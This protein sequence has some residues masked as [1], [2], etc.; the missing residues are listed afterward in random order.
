MSNVQKADP[1]RRLIKVMIALLVLF[2]LLLTGY[3]LLDSYQKGQHAQEQR[4]VIEANNQMIEEYNKALLAQRSEEVPDVAP[5]WPA[6]KAEGIDIVGLKGFAVKGEE[7][8]TVTRSEALL[9][10]LLVVN[11]WH[12]LPADFSL[13]EGQLDSI[14][15]L[16]NRRVPSEKREISLFPVAITALDQMI[17]AAKADGLEYFLVRGGYRSMQTQT[18]YWDK[19]VSDLGASGRLTGDALTEEARKAVAYPGTS[20]Y[21]S[22]F[23][24]ELDAYSSNDPV[25]NQAKFQ[26]TEQAKWLYKN[27]PQYGYVFRFPLAGYPYS[28]TVDKSYKTGINLANMDVYR[29]VGVPHA[30]V[31]QQKGFCLEEYI[32]YLIEQGHIAVY[33][34]GK[35]IHEIFRVEEGSVQTDFLVPAGSSKVEC[36]SDNLG[37]LICAVTY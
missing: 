4:R 28:T 8:Q 22:G 3:L 2:V 5:A 37:G 1:Y 10:G 14:M 32:E 36:S 19:K 34:D 25:L 21:Q 9:G 11:R 6:P 23:S 18:A 24:V 12:A 30:L 27:G 35:L 20:D 13:V 17:A 33:E 31:M 16:T 29:Y 15:T 7:R 26:E